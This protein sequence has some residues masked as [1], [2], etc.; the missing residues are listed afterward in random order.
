MARRVPTISTTSLTSFRSHVDSIQ[1][2]NYLPVSPVTSA[3]EQLQLPPRTSIT[4]YSVPNHY[5][6]DIYMDPD[7][8]FTRYTVAEVKSVQKQ[9]RRVMLVLFD[10]RDVQPCNKIQG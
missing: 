4:T 10:R 2:P 9:L 5:D 6:D 8:L 3:N 7:D 1:S